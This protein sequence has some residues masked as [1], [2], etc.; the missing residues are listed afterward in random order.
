MDAFP[1]AF[2]TTEYLAYFQVHGINS[3]E[4]RAQYL[5]W[6]DFLDGLYLERDQKERAARQNAAKSKSR[7]SSRSRK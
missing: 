2:P 1:S 3:L 5:K 4:E 7:A 6:V